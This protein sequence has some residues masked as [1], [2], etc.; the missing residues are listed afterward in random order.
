VAERLGRRIEHFVFRHVAGAGIACWPQPL[1]SARISLIQRAVLCDLA[2]PHIIGKHA[3]VGPQRNASVDKRPAA[4]PA[5]HKHV[6]VGAQAHII[7]R[8]VRPGAQSFTAHLHVVLEIGKLRRKLSGD[9]FAAAFQH[10]DALAGTRQ[11]RSSNTAAI[12]R[13]N[14]DHVVASIEPV[15]CAGQLGHGARPPFSLLCVP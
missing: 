15:M 4:E 2:R 7:Q 1:F 10:G 14:H 6:H 12:A 5:A 9:N 3:R 8:R 13:T 11:P